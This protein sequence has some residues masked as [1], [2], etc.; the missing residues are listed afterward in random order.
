M[1]WGAVT[2]NCIMLAK[3]LVA[4]GSSELVSQTK[5][6]VEDFR[7]KDDQDLVHIV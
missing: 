1:N 7:L 2:G 5:G 3:L 4:K 6:L